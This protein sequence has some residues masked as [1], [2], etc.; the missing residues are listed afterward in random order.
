MPAPA[1]RVHAAR[2]AAVA[3]GSA[4]VLGLAG[5][6]VKEPEPDLVNGKQL[7]AAK[8]G[9]CHALARA[10]TRGTVGPNLDQAFVRDLRDGFKRDTI[11]GVVHQ[12]ILYPRRGSSMQPGLVKGQDAHDVAAYVAAVTARRGK[13][14]GLLATAV[15]RVGAGKTAVAAKGQLQIDAA[16]GGELLFVTKTARSSPGRLTIRSKNASS[17]PHNIA[18]EGGGVR[19]VG[20]VVQGGG[21]SQISVTVRPGTYTFYC[22]VQGHR[23]GGML[24]RLVVD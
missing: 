9:S 18:L 10:E 16:P 11:R 6:T 23:Q 14:T 20:R 13:D 7:F 21:V 5:C 1:R 3:G 12:Q 2:V 4:L 8:C 24:G 22:S 17:V 15:K 19:A